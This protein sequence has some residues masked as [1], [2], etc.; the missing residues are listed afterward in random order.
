MAQG[1]TQEAA[2][3]AIGLESRTLRNWLK[4]PK[5][6]RMDR[7]NFT[8]P[9]SYSESQQD[10]ILE[11]F[12]RSDVSGLTLQ[13]AFYKLLDLGEYW[14][15]CATLYR[16]FRR[17]NMNK[18]RA[19][20]AEARRRY[21]PTSYMAAERHQVWTWDITYFR[22]QYTGRFYYAYVIID[23]F[24]RYV[25]SAKVYEADN[26]DYAVEFLSEAFDKYRISPG[27]LV[28]HSD[29][30]ASMK[31]TQ[32][33]ALLE[34]KG[35]AFSHS[36]PRVSN[37]N[38]YSESLFRTLKYNGEYRYPHTGFQSLQGAQEWL[39]GFVHHYNE[40]H[41]HRGIRMVTPGSRFRGEGREILAK[42]KK[43]M[44]RAR[45]ENPQRWIQSKICNCEPVGGVWLNPEKGQYEEVRASARF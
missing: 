33:L 45:A 24:S 4:K 15:S 13:Q 35:V 2:C 10:E 18:C 26:A 6:G 12:C 17:R 25:I 40:E 41:Y 9:L 19:Q 38:P 44:E 27:Q 30:G 28:V 36:R 29:N 16:I 39:D 43:V 37:D 31:A 34:Q 11:R 21:R 8:S 32:T 22:S 1:I 7:K 3:E 42:R 14:C 23:V 20:S 5:D